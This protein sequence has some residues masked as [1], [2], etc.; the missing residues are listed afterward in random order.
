M[1]ER[2]KPPRMR[3]GKNIKQ[4][5]TVKIKVRFEHPS[6]TGLGQA[7]PDSSPMFNRAVPVSF[8]RNMLV[9]YGNDLV[10]R[11]SMTSAIANNPLFTFK[12]KATREAPVTV[13]FIDNAGERW[14][15]SEDIKF[16]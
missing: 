4:D 3:I 5:E 14:E 15:A 7:E 1:A 2:I 13:V 10:S 9:Y 8:L 11:F 16:G 12:L 6:F